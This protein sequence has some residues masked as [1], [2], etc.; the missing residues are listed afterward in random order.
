[1][2]RDAGTRTLRRPPRPAQRRDRGVA[3]HSTAL[4]PALGGARMWHYD[5]PGD[6]VADAMRLARAMTFKAAA[7]GLELGGGKGVIC[8]PQAGARPRARSGARCCST[9]PTWSRRSRAAT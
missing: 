9:S 6:G 4:G 2:R 7:A 8:A 3:V 1:M 5:T